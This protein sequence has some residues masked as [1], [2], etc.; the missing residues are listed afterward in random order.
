M[1]ARKSTEPADKP[2]QTPKSPRLV[3]MR[4]EDGKAADVHP[5]MVDDYKLGGYRES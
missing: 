2:A 3:K 5:D 1:A 4:R